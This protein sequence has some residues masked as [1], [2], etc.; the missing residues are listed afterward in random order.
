MSCKKCEHTANTFGLFVD[1]VARPVRFNHEWQ[2][3]VLLKA[4]RQKGNHYHVQ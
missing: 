2:Q 1:E 3:W 4:A